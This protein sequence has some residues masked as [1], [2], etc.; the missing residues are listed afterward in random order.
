[1]NREPL[2]R[3]RPPA[4]DARPHPRRGR[5][6]L[7][8]C[9]RAGHRADLRSRSARSGPADRRRPGSCV[10]AGP[11]LLPGRSAL[12]AATQARALAKGRAVCRGLAGLTAHGM[13][14]VW[15]SRAA[16]DDEAR[17]LTETLASGPLDERSESWGTHRSA[18]GEGVRPLLIDASSD[19]AARAAW[20]AGS[21][22]TVTFYIA[23]RIGTTSP[24]SSKAT[25]IAH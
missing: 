15:T 12:S 19:P 24:W 1:A 20:A 11:W 8:R 14:L 3:R 18:G 2:L 22:E 17:Q 6:P 23:P 25:D 16:T 13:H 21:G 5:A 4:G 10:R 9:V 7:H